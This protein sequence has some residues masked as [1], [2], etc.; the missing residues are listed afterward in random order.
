VVADLTVDENA[1]YESVAESDSVFPIQ[2]DQSDVNQDNGESEKDTN[3]AD[4]E[5]VVLF[6]AA[7]DSSDEIPQE[8]LRDHNHLDLPEIH[9]EGQGD[10]A[11]E[12]KTRLLTDV[13]DLFGEKRKLFSWRLLFYPLVVLVVVLLIMQPDPDTLLVQAQQVWSDFNKNFIQKPKIGPTASVL[14]KDSTSKNIAEVESKEKDSGSSEKASKPK[15]AVKERV[16]TSKRKT[17]K[18]KPAARKNFIEQGSQE[19]KLKQHYF[20]ISDGTDSGLTRQSQ[21]RLAAAIQLLEKYPTTVLKLTGLT[22]NDGSPIV[23]MRTALKHAESVAT[24]VIQAG[25]SKKRVVI[26]GIKPDGWENDGFDFKRSELLPDG[27][28]VVFKVFPVAT[29]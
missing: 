24:Q 3:E 6:D 2:P 15:E 12:V 25:I 19:I 9:I 4:D 29:L 22:T 8:T 1:T 7:N 14:A 27:W 5:P 26:E 20:L 21:L 17:E 11:E 16:K 18:V 13:D 23:Q 10:V 28:V